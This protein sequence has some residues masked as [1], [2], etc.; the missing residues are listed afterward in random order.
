[1]SFIPNKNLITLIPGSLTFSYSL[2]P[3]NK[4]LVQPHLKYGVQFTTK[5]VKGL[6]GKMYEERMRSLGLF[7]LEKKR[8]RGD[9]ITVYSFLVRGSGGAG[10]DL[11]SLVPRDRTCGNDVKLRQGRFR[12]DIRKRFF[13]E[14]VVT[15]WNRLPRDVV[16]APSLSEFRRVGTVLLVM[17]SE[18]LGRPVWCQELDS[19]IVVG[20]FQLGIFYDYLNRRGSSAP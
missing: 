15:H 1:M 6:E 5:M 18:F 11:F 3:T 12:L 10:V 16:T 19:M 20:P 13:T 17:W 8:L 14:R 2:L 9:L 4:Q 7:S